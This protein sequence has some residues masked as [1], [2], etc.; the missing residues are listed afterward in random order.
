MHGRAVISF[1]VV[2]VWGLQGQH[3]P[4]QARS[5]DRAFS[6]QDAGDR[7]LRNYSQ[8]ARSVLFFARVRAGNDGSRKVEVTHLLGAIV[9]EDQGEKNVETPLETVPAAGTIKGRAL[10]SR[11]KPFFRPDVASGL[12]ARLDAVAS[13][14]EP[15]ATSQ[16]L[17]VSAE[18]EQ[19]LTAAEALRRDR[20]A[21]K[22]EPLDL[23]SAALADRSNRAAQLFLEAG[24]TLEVVLD[25]I[26]GN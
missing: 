19:I 10:E 18:L 23:L 6:T 15:V 24:I 7:M 14:A 2:L 16:D 21:Q 3:G 22:V 13:H 11:S 12:L 9:M 1:L 4:S 17:P 20:Q 25:A 5:L 8:R 26:K